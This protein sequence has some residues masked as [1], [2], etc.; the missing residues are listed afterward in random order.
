VLRFGL[1]YKDF[2]K[3]APD[4]QVVISS[5]HLQGESSEDGIPGAVSLH[6]T[7]V[8]RDKGFYGWSGGSQKIPVEAK[9]NGNVKTMEASVGTLRLQQDRSLMKLN[10]R[11]A[12]LDITVLRSPA[13]E[14]QLRHGARTIQTARRP[15]SSDIQ[16][17]K[18]AMSSHPEVFAAVTKHDSSAASTE[19]TGMSANLNIRKSKAYTDTLIHAASTHHPWPRPDQRNE[20]AEPVMIKLE[21]EVGGKRQQV[22]LSAMVSTSWAVGAACSCRLMLALRT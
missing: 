14:V 8:K 7:K 16:D 11:Q 21:V 9:I 1:H 17:L 12:T 15:L 22:E 20:P 4:L 5:L 19:V 13:K 3:G 2:A 10:N 18:A 6:L